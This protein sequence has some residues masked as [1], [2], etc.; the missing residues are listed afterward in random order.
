MAPPPHRF[1]TGVGWGAA[2]AER[3]DGTVVVA[4][5]TVNAGI[6]PDFTLATLTGA[7]GSD[8]PVVP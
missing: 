5:R 8:V 3:A 2:I 6:G 7:D 1:D 4:G